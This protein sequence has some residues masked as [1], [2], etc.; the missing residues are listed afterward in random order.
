MQWLANLRVRQN[1]LESLLQLRFL[2]SISRFSELAGQGWGLTVC[3]S[4]PYPD[5]GAVESKLAEFQ[6]LKITKL[7]LLLSHKSVCPRE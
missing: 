3:I 5:D 7:C 6:E 4:S 2:G 1:H